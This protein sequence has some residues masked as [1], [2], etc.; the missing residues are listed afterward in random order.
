MTEILQPPSD[1][2]PHQTP[3]D[4]QEQSSGW[5]GLL[6]FVVVITVAAWLAEQ[7]RKIEA[8]NAA[9]RTSNTQQSLQITELK[10]E[11]SR[12]KIIIPTTSYNDVSAFE[13]LAEMKKDIEKLKQADAE[14]A[15]QLTALRAAV[16]LEDTDKTSIH[17]RFVLGVMR[18]TTV[19]K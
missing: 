19:T 14:M 6:T 11:N 9:L 15:A 1:V 17:T 7:Y 18:E 8:E 2:P 5:Y 13:Q 4:A 3:A 16:S 10:E 12:L